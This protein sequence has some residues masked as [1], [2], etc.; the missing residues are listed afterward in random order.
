MRRD[1]AQRSRSAVIRNSD[2]QLGRVLADLERRGLREQTDVFV[3]SDH[4]FSTI[5]WKVDV[6]T[7]LSSAGFRTERAALG[8]LRPGDVLV[9]GCGG[10]RSS[11]WAG[12]IRTCA[13]AW[14]PTSRSR[15]GRASSSPGLPL[16]GTFPLSEARID[17][18]GAPDLVVSLHWTSGRSATGAPGLQTTDGTPALKNAGNHAS[19]SPF[20][21]HNTLV[22]AGPDFH[23]GVVDTLPSGN[24]DLAPTILWILGLRGEIA[25]M[26]GRVLA[27][28]LS[29]T[30]R[31]SGPTRSK[32]LRP[33][34]AAGGR[35]EAVPGGQ[36]GQRGPLPGRGQR[37]LRAEGALGSIRPAPHPRWCISL[38]PGW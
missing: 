24:T 21:M 34:A 12:T 31:R 2:A 20:D 33:R 29:S 8:G 37:S 36:R 17:S 19:L 3:V 11:T 4:G 25:R 5:G 35:V 1:P 22:A 13:G 30:R 9:V 10:A 15:T 6:A 23:R 18:P 7:E 28:A 16:E 38:N 32:G 26:D 27:E 14:R